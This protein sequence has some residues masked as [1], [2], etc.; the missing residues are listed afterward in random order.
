MF[1]VKSSC[2]IFFYRSNP[3]RY[4]A[5]VHIP[6]HGVHGFQRIVNADSSGT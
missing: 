1:F 6:A 5:E 2:L 4:D 3:A